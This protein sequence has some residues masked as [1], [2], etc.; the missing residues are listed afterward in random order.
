[1]TDKTPIGPSLDKY[2][3]DAMERNYTANNQRVAQLR[4]AL[5]LSLEAMDQAHYA[6]CSYQLAIQADD[7]H[8]ER[9]AQILAAKDRLERSIHRAR[10]TLVGE[11]VR[12]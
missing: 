4:Y 11:G 12:E 6:L 8:I 10:E 9:Y 2:H 3:A 7:T 1:M 5:R